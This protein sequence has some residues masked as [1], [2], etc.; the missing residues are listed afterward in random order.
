MHHVKIYIQNALVS[1]L[2][3]FFTSNS[4]RAAKV[5][6]YYAHKSEKMEHSQHC[7]FSAGAQVKNLF[8]EL[9]VG[10]LWYSEGA[11]SPSASFK[12]AATHNLHADRM[13]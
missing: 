11:T 13:D 6:I 9:P 8:S 7:G 4:Q 12:K 5:S 10:A 1:L 3:W 2:I